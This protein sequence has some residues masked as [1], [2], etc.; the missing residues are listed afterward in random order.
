MVEADSFDAQRDAGFDVVTELSAAGFEG[1]QEIGR[2]GLGIVYRCTQVAADRDVAVKV[3]TGD[4][5]EVRDQ[6]FR[7]Q[8]AM[9]RLTGHPNIVSML[10][11]GETTSG[12]PYLVMP[13]FPRGSL[14]ERLQADGPLSLSDTLHIGVRIAGALESAHRAGV[15][16]RDI[17]PANILLTDYDEPALTDF[18]IADVSSSPAVTAPE[19]LDGQAP[20]RGSD[21]YGLGATLLCALTRDVAFEGRI[22]RQP[23]TQ[24]VRVATAEH[25]DACEIG[26]PWDVRAVI[27]AAMSRDPRDRPTAAALGERLRRIQ[28]ERGFAV[29]DMAVREEPGSESELFAVPERPVPQGVPRIHSEALHEGTGNLP[30]ELSTFVDRRT[31]LSEVANLLPGSRLVTLT[32]IGGVGKSRLAQRVAHKVRSKFPNGA[33]LVELGE[34]RDDALLPDVVAAVLGLRSQGVISVLDT[35]VE[36]LA[37]Y[38]LLLVLD[39]C[40]HVIDA[41]AK[42][43]EALLRA[44][45]NVRILATSREALGI[46][47]ETVY[48]LQPLGIP[49]SSSDRG[50]G[51]SH[52]V[53]LFVERAAAAVPG[54]EMNEANQRGIAEICARLDGLPL[55]IE[56]AAAR[57]RTMSVEQI[58]TRLIDRYA[59]LTRGGRGT[60]KRQQTLRYSI[61]WSYDL[62]TPDE[63]RLWADL[64]V[65][66]GGFELDAV[67]QVCAG[68]VPESLVLD[69]LSALV[70]KSILVRQETDGA[71]RF[72]MLETVQE[73]GREKA[74]E[75][76]QRADLDRR[77]RDWCARLVRGADSEMIGPHQMDWVS[78]LERELPNLRKALEFSLSEDD[79]SALGMVTNLYLFWGLRGRLHEG[80]RW[81]E[82]AL[83]H[84]PAS[85]TTDRARALF[86][87]GTIV[88]LTGDLATANNRFAE[89]R[90]LAEETE[91]PLVGALVKHV[92]ANALIALGNVG[93]SDAAA[94]LNDAVR[95]YEACGDIGM[96]LD[97]QLSLGWAYALGGDFPRAVACHEKTLAMTATSGESIYRSWALFAAGF[98][99]WRAGDAERAKHLLEDGVRLSALIAEPLVAAGC[100]ETLAWIASDRNEPRRAAVLM[101]AADKLGRLAGT[102]TLM[103]RDLLTY[104]SD[105]MRISRDALGPRAFDRARQEGAAMSL[106]SAVRLALDEPAP[107]TESAPPILT[108]RERQVADLVAEG[109]TNRAIATRLV[110]SQRTAQGHVEHI[111]VKLGF[112]SRAQ[113]AAWVTE[114]ST[115]SSG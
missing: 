49:D 25:P 102:A 58:Q 50:S 74:E 97:A 46:G 45:P 51:H 82:R 30:L 78:R 89:L 10:E 67:E 76:G 69:T 87:A 96:Q 114:H 85:R 18:G 31:Q 48:P 112:T 27:E 70:D 23:V 12:R 71:V 83:G 17:R 2:G 107:A 63:K 24:L 54:F 4:V 52:A 91:D 66:T 72:R 29:D 101:G 62:C 53:A 57:L 81:Y 88:G 28:L 8:R 7:E 59:L 104:R 93:E 36:A 3:L 40:E 79:E 35:L 65:F 34:L 11:V 1:A 61:S 92:D 75:S 32:G 33:W 113:I 100:L 103:V 111:L 77:H 68:D 73:F 38:D 55:A 15:V 80:Y 110:I 56:L 14:G 94:L 64:S 86:A 42:L 22:G 106:D 41:A 60:P 37:P 115:E 109:L 90:A 99:V 20:S 43:S 21:V 108:K 13:Y 44:C 98:A 26:I 105:C 47:G 95:T 84:S 16:H 6:F 9:G 39:N 19:V 5:E